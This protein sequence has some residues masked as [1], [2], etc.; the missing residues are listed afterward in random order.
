[1]LNLAKVK[2]DICYPRRLIMS[3]VGV[4]PDGKWVWDGSEWIPN[5]QYNQSLIENTSHYCMPTKECEYTGIQS[6]VVF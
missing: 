4:S 3:G 1:M 5:T 6:M 2:F